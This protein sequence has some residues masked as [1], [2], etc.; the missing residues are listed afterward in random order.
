MNFEMPDFQLAAAEIFVLAMVCIVLLFD[1]FSNDPKRRWTYYLSLITVIGAAV[2]TWFTAAEGTEL[3][4]SGTYVADHAGL[5]LK[6]ATYVSMV[7]V[8]IYSME[9]LRDRLLVKGEYFILALFAML[10]IMVMIS[11]AH[12]LSIYLGLELL[13]LSLYAMVAFDRDSPIAA[14]SAMKYFVLGAIASGTLLYGMSMLYGVS[15]S[16]ELTQI[17]ATMSDTGVSANSRLVMLLGLSFVLVG[18]AF[19]LG[20][21]PFHMWI[22]DV[23]H[24]APTATTLFIGSTAKIASFA[25]MLRILIDGL[26]ALYADW[27]DMLMVMSVLSIALGNIV[28]IAQTNLKRMLAYSTISH[29]GFILMGFLAPTSAGVEAALLYTVVYVI[30]SAGAFGMIILLGREGFEADEI[31]DFKGLFRRSPWFAMIMMLLMFSMA[32]VPPLVGFYPKLN[33]IM[34]A[35]DAGLVWVALVGV[36]FSVVGAYYY[37]RVI[38]VM[39]FDQPTDDAAPIEASL[40]MRAALSVNGLAVLVLG[41]LPGALITWIAAAF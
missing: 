31:D 19:K 2:V 11:G 36:F 41:L 25:L 24:G 9:Y 23:Y 13:S 17:A 16:L 37:L 27:R 6:M 30:M 33:V 40:S 14:E 7:F 4:F 15:G 35:L 34:S 28:A 38:K 39:L 29:V 5:I 18:M 12:F 20:A 10:G 1:V 3:T 22:P 21:V 32:G 8:F 26:G